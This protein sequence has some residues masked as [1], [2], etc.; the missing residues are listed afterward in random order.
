MKHKTETTLRVFTAART[1]L[2]R[3]RENHKWNCEVFVNN[4]HM[5]L[6][7]WFMSTQALVQHTISFSSCHG[8]ET[9]KTLVAASTNIPPRNVERKR[10][11]S[12]C[13]E[14]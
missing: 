8:I 14:K 12:G 5:I 4:Q 7:Q 9:D 1:F 3:K 13:M 6:F 2:V 11:K 10:E